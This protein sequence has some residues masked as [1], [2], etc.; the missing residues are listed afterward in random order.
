MQVKIKTF[1]LSQKSYFTYKNKRKELK[2][3]IGK[4]KII[5]MLVRDS[6]ELVFEVLADM[7]FVPTRVEHLWYPPV[8]LMEGISEK[9]EELEEG[10]KI[11]LYEIIINDLG[12]GK[13]ITKIAKIEYKDK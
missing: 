5:E 9:F 8:F 6:P 1:I 11:P 2:M 4:F 13:I 7:K 3:K 12:N 10:E